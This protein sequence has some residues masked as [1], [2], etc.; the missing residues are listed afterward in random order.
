MI[1][2]DTNYLIRGVSQGSAEA[3]RMIGWFQAGEAMV[4]PMAAWFE[5]LCGPVTM[6]QETAV[7]AF[8]AQIVPFDEK[9][10]TAAAGLFNKAGRKR[11]LRVDAMIAGTA[12]AIGAKLATGNRTDFA[13][14]VE[15][16]LELA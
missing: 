8:L 5:F 1:C 16:G 3:S 6:D 7:R 4:T 10:A 11:H 15:L 13:P 2:L 9:Q 14:F 12:V